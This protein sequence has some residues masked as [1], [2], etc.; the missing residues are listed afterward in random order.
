MNLESQ[1]QKLTL[2]FD[3]YIE[4]L[5]KFL[6]QNASFSGRCL[7]RIQMISSEI[8]TAEEQANEEQANEENESTSM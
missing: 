5:L 7:K 6:K 8:V 1:K 3:A 4:R 2:Q